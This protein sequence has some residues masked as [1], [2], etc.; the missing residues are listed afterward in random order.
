MTLLL[1]VKHG[2]H[3]LVALFVFTLK[4]PN[5]ILHLWGELLSLHLLRCS[6]SH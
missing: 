2:E 6:W 3:L 5:R 4:A 1:G